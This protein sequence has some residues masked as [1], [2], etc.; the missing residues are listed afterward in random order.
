MQLIVKANGCYCKNDWIPGS[1]LFTALHNE[2]L[3][4]LQS[5]IAFNRRISY[6]VYISVYGTVKS[7]VLGIRTYKEEVLDM[8]VFKRLSEVKEITAKWIK[9]YN[10]ERPHE[11]VA[12]LRPTEYLASKQPMENPIITR[13]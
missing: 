4:K 9:E 11:S 10:D 7:S 13:H 3:R 8:Y 5:F 2:L 1:I 6:I 12:N